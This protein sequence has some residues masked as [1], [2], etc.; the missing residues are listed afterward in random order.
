MPDK[1]GTRFDSGQPI[2]EATLD[3]Q[4]FP[5]SLDLLNGASSLFVEGHDALPFCLAR[6]EME[7]G[8]SI[9][10]AIQALQGQT[11][12]FL[13]P[14]PTPASSEQGGPLKRAGEGSNGHQEAVQFLL[15]DRAWDPLRPF[16]YISFDEQG[17]LRSVFPTP[18][19]DNFEKD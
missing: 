2:R 10:I 19:G 5:Q 3:G 6:R 14:G 15:R 13:T 7:P 1:E 18:G 17:T 12:D 9:G 4:L 16:G 8:S 11:S